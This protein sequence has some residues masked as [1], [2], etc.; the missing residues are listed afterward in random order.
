MC[1]CSVQTSI[2]QS[3]T[4]SP[5]SYVSYKTFQN[6]VKIM[7]H[8][9]NY[10]QKP[11]LNLSCQLSSLTAFTSFRICRRSPE[12]L[13]LSVETQHSCLSTMPGHI[14]VTVLHHAR[15]FHGLY[16]GCRWLNKAL[17]LQ[18]VLLWTMLEV[19]HRTKEAKQASLSLKA[20]EEEEEEEGEE[21]ILQY[22]K[23]FLKIL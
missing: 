15:L 19:S 22:T 10:V 2:H 18:T 5:V 23:D 1:S 12:Y 20:R 9:Y 11:F 17:L 13:G 4:P 21:K 7:W 6:G 8:L 16:R 14:S 3:S